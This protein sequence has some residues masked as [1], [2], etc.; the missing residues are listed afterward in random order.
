MVQVSLGAGNQYSILA[1]SGILW[2][3]DSPRLRSLGAM[4]HAFLF[5]RIVFLIKIFI[6]FCNVLIKNPIFKDKKY[7]KAI[8][9][10]GIL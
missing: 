8:D 6:Y 2:T 5:C 1:S 4:G 10:L 3:R 9:E 7:K